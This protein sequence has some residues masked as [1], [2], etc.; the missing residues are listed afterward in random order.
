MARLALL[1]MLALAL[2]PGI[3]RIAQE[4]GTD[5][6]NRGFVS[7]LGAMCT[8]QGLAY[9][10]AIAAAEAADFS[11]QTGGEG[12]SPSHPHPH[13]GGDCDY[14]AIASA[15]IVTAFLSL[16]SPALAGDDITLPSRSSHPVL[17]HYPLGLGSRGPPLTA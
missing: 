2:L 11:L 10:P 13:A 3:G 14:C 7:A 6:A 4:A 17:W 12:R 1:A 9:N 5:V 15:S 8:S 16:G